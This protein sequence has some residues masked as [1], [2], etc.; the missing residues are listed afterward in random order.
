M[1]TSINKLMRPRL[2]DVNEMQ[3]IELAERRTRGSGADEGGRRE[4]G[5]GRVNDLGTWSPS[6]PRVSSFRSTFFVIVF[7]PS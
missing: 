4:E 3:N 6:C 7:S 2:C 5:R 1:K